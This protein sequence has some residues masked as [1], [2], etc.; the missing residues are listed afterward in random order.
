VTEERDA[1]GEESPPPERTTER[2]PSWTKRAAK[3]AAGAAWDD[4]SD[5]GRRLIDTGRFRLYGAWARRPTRGGM[6][7]WAFLLG[8][9]LAG[10]VSLGTQTRIA[11]RLPSELDWRAAAALLERDSRA[12]DVVVVAPSWAERARGELPARVPVFSLARYVGEP[13]VGVRRAWLVSLSGV[14]FVGDRLA[15]EIAARASA[16]GGAQRIGALTVTRYDLAQPRRAIAFLPDWLGQAKVKLGEVP[17]EADGPTAH[18]CPGTPALRVARVAREVRE[19][20]G[21]PRP[22][23]SA[24]LGSAAEGPL[25]ITFPTV[26]MGLELDGGVGVVGRAP[27]DATVRVALQLDGEEATAVELAPGAPE[28]KRF[29]V[30]TGALAAEP[31]DVTLVLSSPH[32]AGRTVCFDLWTLP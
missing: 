19:V 27:S 24:A 5:T 32:P 13:L 7:A 14:P 18:R 11:A 16:D 25:S 4:L 26:P 15:R 30:R 9:A 3:V 10:A 2:T 6:V 22:C 1:S 8:T 29:V 17:C 23:V 28:W 12:G 21:A 31:H 20:G